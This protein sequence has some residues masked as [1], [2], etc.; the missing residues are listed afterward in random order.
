M[1][2]GS[3]FPPTAADIKRLS[4]FRDQAFEV[5]AAYI[6]H[7]TS[8]KAY[9]ALLALQQDLLKLRDDLWFEGANIDWEFTRLDSFQDH[10]WVTLG[11]YIDY[12]VPND[13]RPVFRKLKAQLWKLKTDLWKEQHG[14][15]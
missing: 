7:Y 2:S 13:E 3:M 5:V 10:V 8:P 15:S 4:E 9:A 14:Q 1:R 6:K 12:Y 11:R